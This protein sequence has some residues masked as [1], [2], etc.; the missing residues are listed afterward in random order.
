MK[1]MKG[2]Q[3][4]VWDKIFPPSVGDLVSLEIEYHSK[5]VVG[6]IIRIGIIPDTKEMILFIRCRNGSTYIRNYD[7]IRRV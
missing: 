6:K 7:E 5:K 4:D 3:N 2:K 1:E